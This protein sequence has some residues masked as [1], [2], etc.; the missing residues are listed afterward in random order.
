[1]NLVCLVE[2]SKP[3]LHVTISKENILGVVVNDE[4]SSYQNI[5]QIFCSGFFLH[6]GDFGS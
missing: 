5:L 6:S 1:M 2:I 3:S 4:I